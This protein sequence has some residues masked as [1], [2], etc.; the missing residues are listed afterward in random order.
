MIRFAAVVGLLCSAC[1]FDAGV[2]IDD[3]VDD[4]PGTT[5]PGDVPQSPEGDTELPPDAPTPANCPAQVM[6]S[7]AKAY[8]PT[9]FADDEIVLPAAYTFALPR[10]IEVVQGA[11]GDDCAFLDIH[12]EGQD[13][14][15]CAFEGD[16]GGGGGGSGFGFGEFDDEHQGGGSGGTEYQLRE[17]RSGSDA[18]FSFCGS[19]NSNGPKIDYRDGDPVTADRLVLTIDDGDPNMGM[20]QVELVLAGSCD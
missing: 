1:V 13:V 16:G 3:G 6:L 20:T 11:P 18:R 4:P 14:V 9:S 19:N 17:C 10:D 5:D 2:S 7:A 12:L 8:N 15:R